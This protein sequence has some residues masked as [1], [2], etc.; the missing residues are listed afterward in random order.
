MYEAL[1]WLRHD[2]HASDLLARDVQVNRGWTLNLRDIYSNIRNEL[3]TADLIHLRR[4]RLVIAVQSVDQTLRFLR[5]LLLSLG[6]VLQTIIGV[7]EVL[8]VGDRLG[9]MVVTIG[10]TKRLQRRVRGD[11]ATRRRRKA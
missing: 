11:D 5:H 10:V 2:H 9:G 7:T 4:C 8:D 3:S 6:P 1:A